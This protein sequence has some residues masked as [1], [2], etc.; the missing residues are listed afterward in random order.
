M[1]T[2]E[3]VRRTL[4][5]L[6]R[7]VGRLL[8]AKPASP[9]PFAS[10]PH[11]RAVD[12]IGADVTDIVLVVA[13]T[14]ARL[15]DDIATRC[16]SATIQLLSSRPLSSTQRAE[17]PDAVVYSHCPDTSSRLRRLAQCPQPQ[18]LIELGLEHTGE[19]VDTFRALFGLVAAG[20]RYVIDS[21]PP[22]EAPAEALAEARR[23]DD[24]LG[25]LAEKA[26]T[27]QGEH[28]YDI[29]L[30]R[31]LGAM[32]AVPLGWIVTKRLSHQWMIRDSRANQLLKARF[33][34]TWGEV[35]DTKP[36]TTHVSRA[37]GFTHGEGLRALRPEFAVPDRWLRRYRGVTCFARKRARLGDY[38]LPDTFRNPKMRLLN[39]RLLHSASPSL[40]RAAGEQ[41]QAGR[42]LDGPFFYLDSEYFSHFGHILTDVVSN[43]WGWQLAKEQAPD[44]RPL[45]TLRADQTAIPEFQR[46]ILT[47]LDIDPDAVEYVRPGEGVQ[48]EELYGCTPD[49][50]MPRYCAPELADVWQRI[51]AGCL[52]HELTQT[53]ELI[54]VARRPREIRTCL[55]TEE[56]EEFF[57]RLGFTIVY[58]E[59]L[60]FGDQIATFANARVVAGFAGSGMFNT[61]FAPDADRADP[62]RRQLHRPQRVPD[63][64]TGG[65]RH[66]LFLVAGAAET[67]GSGLELGGLPLELR[68]RPGAVRPRDHR[69]AVR[70]GLRCPPRAGLVPSASVG[71]I[72]TAGSGHVRSPT[73]SRDRVLYRHR[74]IREASS[75][76]ASGC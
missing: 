50:A 8:S 35:I 23:M 73:G 33:G 32:R 18:L 40:A 44:L 29:E 21:V 15:A 3:P 43:T 70:V 7:R 45:L 9:V 1:T 61:M 48:V 4:G 59:D 56:V 38:W 25:E 69:G 75:G 42:T 47:A 52:N 49:W 58:P 51:R 34:S 41:E 12:E 22:P 53:P 46:Q 55:N 16:P 60:P 31:S 68:V 57:A 13:R 5:S 37:R 63:Q 36:A 26:R 39:H 74:H 28:T 14:G 62:D 2:I 54:F 72:P 17:L 67:P 24:H 66:P 76:D 65:W 20:G 30:G 11:H 27:T 64:V 6:R 71:S 10:A 19:R